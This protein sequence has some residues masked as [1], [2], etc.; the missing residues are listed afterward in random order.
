MKKL[1]FLVILLLPL[2]L[3]C[4]GGGGSS[5]GGDGIPSDPDAPIL[6]TVTISPNSVPSGTTQ[7]VFLYFTFSDRNGDLDGGTL[8]LIDPTT[9]KTETGKL[10]DKFAGI[11]EGGGYHYGRMTV[12][13]EKGTFNV[14]IWLAD[15]AGHKSN[16]VYLSWTQTKIRS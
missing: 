12:G 6:K 4:G 11:T 14:P 10:S 13:N 3:S 7:Y 8:S 5:S 2:I 1:F 15:K 16:I 9:G